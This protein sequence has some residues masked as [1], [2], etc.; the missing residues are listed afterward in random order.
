MRTKE[1]YTTFTIVAFGLT[2]AILGTFQIY[3][4]RES[5]RIQADKAA[6]RAFAVSAGSE[7]YSENCVA[8]HGE[9]G[10]GLIGPALNSLPLLESTP[11]EALFSLTRTGIPGTIMPAWGQAFGGPFTDEQITQLVA[12]IR[13]WEGSAPNPTP[14]VIYSDPT[15]GAAIF[16]RTCSICHGENGVGSD[17]A[18]ALNDLER[19]N[20][21]DDAWYRNTISHGR[22]AKGMPTW[23]T[24]LSPEQINDLV[25]LLAAWRQ[26]KQVLADIP[27]AVYI[28]NALFAIQQFDRV[29]AEF[30]LKASLSQAN[31]AQAEKIQEIIGLIQENQLFEA[32]SRLI[33][34]L[35]PEE[36]GKAFFESF[37]S[38]CHGLDGTGGIGPNLHANTFVQSLRDEE[39]IAFLLDG[40]QGTAM[41]GFDGILQ[42]GELLS[43][44]Y[45][46]RIWQE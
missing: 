12:F 32:E 11:D 30:F 8:C 20:E 40:R 2:L 44:I 27:L 26:G 42:E 1:N 35:P 41:N 4:M 19:L 7:L 10:E 3:I 36:M 5:K 9:N 14:I 15:R 39:L 16:E 33:S 21:L 37:C 23:G 22:P 25:A 38:S 45:L 17:L 18:P 24:V 13:S 31:D 34:L 29:D 6:D 46:L 43:I 28:S